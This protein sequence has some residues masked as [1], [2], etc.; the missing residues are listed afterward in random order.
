MENKKFYGLCYD[1]IFKS[2]IANPSETKYINLLLS[3]ILEENVEVVDFIPTELPVKNKNMKVDTL[4][5]IIKREDGSMINIEIN[6][7]FSKA[8]KERNLSYYSNL[9][10]QR[11]MRGQKTSGNIIHLDINRDGGRNE[12]EV[13]YVMNENKEKYSEDFKIITINLAK[14]KKNWYDKNIKGDKSHIYLVMLVLGREEL[15]ELSKVDEIV[16]EVKEKVFTLNEEG[17]LIR[18]IS[19]E[20]E[21]TSLAREEGEMLVRKRERK[22]A[23]V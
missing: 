9:Y 1:R 22:E 11:I 10:S 12:K 2:V 17:K 14:Y 15:E 7:N 4:D 8:V 13:Y 3:D 23:L 5:I 20:E 6:T 18:L 21:I 19:R 16:K